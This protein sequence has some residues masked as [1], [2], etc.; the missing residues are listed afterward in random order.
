MAG[1]S[2][3]LLAVTVLA[4]WIQADCC[5]CPADIH[6]PVC[7]TDGVT[8][9]NDCFLD[10]AGVAQDYHGECVPDSGNVKKDEGTQGKRGFRKETR[11]LC[12]PGFWC[13]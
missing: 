1:K 10:C 12:P 11:L 8:Y 3:L 5:E 9:E 6:L 2:L 7:G 4:F 13:R